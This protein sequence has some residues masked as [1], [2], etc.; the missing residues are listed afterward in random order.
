MFILTFNHF[1]ALFHTVHRNVG[2]D[3]PPPPRFGLCG[4]V[5]VAFR[6]RCWSIFRRRRPRRLGTSKKRRFSKII[7][8]IEDRIQE[9]RVWKIVWKNVYIFRKFA[10]SASICAHVDFLLVTHPP[11]FL[12]F[13]SVIEMILTFVLDMF[14]MFYICFRY[15]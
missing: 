12:V 10:T 14:S 7:S 13:I 11:I 6:I 5:L 4:S 1:Y 3:G 8:K 15:C 9:N 2:L